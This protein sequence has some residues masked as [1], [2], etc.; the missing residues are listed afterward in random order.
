MSDKRVYVIKNVGRVPTKDPNT[1]ES[2]DVVEEYVTRR[3]HNDVSRPVGF[4]RERAI[5]IAGVMNFDIDEAVIVCPDD[6]VVSL[7]N[8]IRKLPQGSEPTLQQMSEGLT[9]M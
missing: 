9:T 3:G 1:G 7:D 4:S 6:L 2:T 5:V 8:S